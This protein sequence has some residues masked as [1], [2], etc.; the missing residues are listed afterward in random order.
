MTN[1]VNYSRDVNNNANENI[2]VTSD[3]NSSLGGS[4]PFSCPIKS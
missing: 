4:F 2:G 1:N 3:V